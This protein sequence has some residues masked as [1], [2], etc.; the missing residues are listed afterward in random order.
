ML[1]KIPG[2]L[3][4][5]L[6]GVRPGLEKTV[7]CEDGLQAP[8]T[9]TLES[10]AFTDGGALP[11]AHT[12]DGDKSSP[13]LGY[14]GVPEGAAFVVLVV[15]DADSP[16]PAPIVHLLAY[17]LPPADRTFAAGVFTGGTGEAPGLGFNSFRKLGW[18]PPDPPTGHGPHRYVFQAYALARAAGLAGEVEKKQVVAALKDNVLARGRLIGVYERRS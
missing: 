17:D 3:G 2:V 16:T 4:E 10:P 13:P 1:E 14:S 6:K 9:L 11:P 15:E 8:E 12:E 5:A 18:L 7:W